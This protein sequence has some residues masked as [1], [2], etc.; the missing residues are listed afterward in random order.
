MTLYAL[1][2]CPFEQHC[3]FR[4]SCNT[5][6]QMGMPMETLL[7]SSRRDVPKGLSREMENRKTTTR[8]TSTANRARTTTSHA[9]S[10]ELQHRKVYKQL[11]TTG[12]A[13]HAHYQLL[14]AVP[15]FHNRLGYL[16][17]IQTCQQSSGSIQ[18]LK[19]VQYF[20][21]TLGRTSAFKSPCSR[22]L[23][24]W[25]IFASF[26]NDKLCRIQMMR[27]YMATRKTSRPHETVF[28]PG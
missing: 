23:I 24:I 22:F 7:G 20:W 3:C 27:F 28:Q 25:Y 15:L 2:F 5:D 26:P 21:G 16:L 13:P 6:D 1:S 8:T 9:R 18:K 17:E 11:R 19:K 12:G 14:V 10:P 4:I